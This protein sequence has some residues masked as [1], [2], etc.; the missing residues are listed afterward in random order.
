[1]FDI[2]WKRQCVI[3]SQQG[4]GINNPSPS[5]RWNVIESV[6]GVYG[7]EDCVNDIAE[8]KFDRPI[9]IKVQVYMIIIVPTR[10]VR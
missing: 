6:K 7:H 8:I 5:Q 2:G 10:T 1:M 9:A 3:Y 4:D